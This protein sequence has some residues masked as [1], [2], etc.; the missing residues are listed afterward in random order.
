MSTDSD[1]STDQEE[2]DQRA[3]LQ[4]DI[5]K[6]NANFKMIYFNFNSKNLVYVI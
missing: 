6:N 4:P 3:T 1:M 2:T 5:L